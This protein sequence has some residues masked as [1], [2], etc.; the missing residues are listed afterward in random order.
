MFV[1]MI[2]DL[3]IPYI[4]TKASLLWVFKLGGTSVEFWARLSGS[5]TGQIKLLNIVGNQVL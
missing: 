4:L 5:D 1:S 2:K 3:E